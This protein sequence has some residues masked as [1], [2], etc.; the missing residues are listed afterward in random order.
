MKK[1]L[2]IT[3]WCLSGALC[4]GLGIGSTF[5]FSNMIQSTQ[6]NHHDEKETYLRI[7]L[8]ENNENNYISFNKDLNKY[9]HT[10]AFESDTFSTYYYKTTQESDT[11]ILVDSHEKAISSSD[12]I[13]LKITMACD[14]NYPDTNFVIYQTDQNYIL[15]SEYSGLGGGLMFYSYRDSK[16]IPIA[17]ETV[18]SG[19]KVF[20]IK[21]SK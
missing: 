13:L 9:S 8:N 6:N 1:S 18:F 20:G 12:D 14:K 21:F 2:K 7:A 11:N 4:F 5:L 16:I 3:I 15:S 17:D 10:K 19:K